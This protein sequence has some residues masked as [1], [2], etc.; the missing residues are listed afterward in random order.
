MICSKCNTLNDNDNK[1]C[2]RCGA[3]LEKTEKSTNLSNHNLA[4]LNDHRTNRSTKKTDKSNNKLRL[5]LISFIFVLLA[6]Y[7]YDMEQ[8]QAYWKGNK[9]LQEYYL[10][11]MLFINP[12]YQLQ[13]DTMIVKKK[14]AIQQQKK[15]KDSVEIVKTVEPEYDYYEVLKKKKVKTFVKEDTIL[16][17]SESDAEAAEK[18]KKEN[19]QIEKI[20]YAKDNK[21]MMLI[22]AQK[23]VMG[24]DTGSELETPA[25][26]VSVNSFYM[27]AY[28]VTNAEFLRFLKDSGYKKAEEYKHFSDPKFNKN[29]QPM[30]DVSYEDASAYATWAGK[31]L[32]TEEE[33]ECAA[34]SG[35]NWL[36]PTG[37]SI[38]RSVAAIEGN[39]LTGQS[40]IVGLYKPNLY[41]IYDL[42]GNVEEWV[43]GVLNRYP[44]NDQVNTFYGKLRVTRGGNWKSDKTN[45]VT[46]RRSTLRISG[47]TGLIGFRCVI[48]ANAVKR[49]Y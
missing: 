34:K 42:A 45:L 35:K 14:E 33:W 44:G 12:A 6:F 10:K 38:D 21:M 15:K 31:R 49:K 8:I 30:V 17:K 26:N 27:D 16:Y 25:H 2:V 47:S 13:T 23:F 24:S 37:D 20:Y 4:Y 9:Q 22:P 48:S 18:L 11:T 1:K 3:K 32:P 36:Y 40:E 43:S 29:R 7:L 28:E 39:S 19:K 41:G 46:H 5:I